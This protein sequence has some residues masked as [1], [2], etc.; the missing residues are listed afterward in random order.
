MTEFFMIFALLSIWF[1][2]IITL[3]V[4]F[5]AVHAIIQRFRVGGVNAIKP[6]PKYP[7][8]TII[9]P[10]HN[11]AIVIQD[12]VYALLHLD[13]PK[14][15]MEIR[16]VADNCSD[17]TFKLAKAMSDRPEYKDF[18]IQIIK[19]TGTGGKAGVLNDVLEI[20]TG[21]WIC[22]YDADAMPQ[23]NALYFLIQKALE[24]EENYAAVFGR[25]KT[26]NYRQNFLTRCI[27]LEIITT[28]KIHHI[29]LWHL[30]KIGRIP[31]TNFIIKT[32]FV[33]SIGGWDNGALTE[34][35]AISFKIMQQNKLIALAQNSEAFQ[36][37]PETLQAY[38][39]QRKRWAKGNY[40]VILDNFHHIFKRK[41]NWRI[42]LEVLYY[43]GTF[44]WFNVAILISNF[45]FIVN[46][47]SMV[48]KLFYPSFVIPFTFG[49]SNRQLSIILLVNWVLMFF[50]YLLQINIGLVSQY[51]QSTSKNLLYSIASYFTYSQLFIFVATNAFFSLMFDMLLHRDGSKWYKTQRF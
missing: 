3:V 16:V 8:V 4:L 46:F 23:E 28:Q 29:G 2:I 42:K 31:G 34:D 35:T 32:D 15:A 38:Y 14:E 41:S 36:Q 47:V 50:I 18:N 11:E 6:L 1:S 49:A 40:E 44:F 33:R 5:G 25:N 27:N 37:E 19:R 17:E 30:F 26:R 13:Y 22:V 21:D 20:A 24:D 7:K 39:Y 10:A 45:L 9:V 43:T 12:T 51:G 48:T